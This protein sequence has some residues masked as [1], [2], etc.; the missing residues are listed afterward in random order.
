MAGTSTSADGLRQ[1]RLFLVD[2]TPAG[3]I[4]ADLVNWTGKVLVAPRSR[5]AQLIAREEAEKTGIYLLIGPDPNRSMELKLYVGE[6]DNIRKRIRRHDADEASDFFDRAAFVDSKDDNLTKAHARFLESQIIRLTK[7]AGA[8]TLANSTH[9]EFEGLPEADRSDM[10]FF[11]TQLQ[12][13]LPILGF[14]LF[15][16]AK[17]LEGLS[18]GEAPPQFEMNVA[19]IQASARENDT[20][21]IVLAGSTARQGGSASFPKGY[22]ELRDRL[23][24][25]GK[26]I[27]AGSDLYRFAENVWFPSPTT[28]AAVILARSASGPHEWTLKGTAQSYR[29]W[30]AAKLDK[31]ET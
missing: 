15:H 29:D 19:G 13:V 10:T 31:T 25:D 5:L 9:P 17:H 7:E 20:G 6:A 27:D 1:I 18:E 12:K 26:I 4:T 8:L 22:R 24:A 23:V 14:E 30:P 3:L 2:G 28:A 16:S 21:F 11:M